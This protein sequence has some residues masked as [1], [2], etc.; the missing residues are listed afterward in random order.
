MS[1]YYQG[2]FKPKNPKKYKGDPT[3]IVYRSWWEFMYMSELDND[4][5][6]IS[7]GSEELI[8]PYRSP[9][10]GK[11][12]RYFP[13]FVVTKI[14]K[15]GKKHTFLIEIKPLSQT[16]QPEVKQKKNKRYL[17]EV[18]TWGINQAKWKQAESYC[19]DRGWTFQ[20]LTEKELGIKN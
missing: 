10:D 5:K 9:I 14:N 2:L 20:I 7:W 6:V 11:L 8:I 17:T 16:K 1:K 12:H 4:D 15:E 18:A 13:D 19:K 3:K